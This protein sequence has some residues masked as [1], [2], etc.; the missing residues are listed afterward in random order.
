MHGIPE[1]QGEAS[2][3][4][5]AYF[6]ESVWYLKPKTAGINKAVVRSDDGVWLGIHDSSGE[7]YIGTRAGVIKVRTIR[8]NGIRADR[9]NAELFQKR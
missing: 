1:N 6:G 3:K 9:W 4:A 8:R 2:G 5:L 7:V